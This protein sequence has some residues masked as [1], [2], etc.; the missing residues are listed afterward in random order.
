MAGA[1]ASFS[2][3]HGVKSFARTS[4]HKGAPTAPVPGRGVGGLK[5]S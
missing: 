5:K 2:S 1:I 4:A 3:E